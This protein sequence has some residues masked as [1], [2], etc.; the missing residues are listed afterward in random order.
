MTPYKDHILRATAAD[1]QIRAFAASTKDL[2]EYARTIH[3]ASPVAAI[4]LGRLLTAVAMMGTMMKND[5]DK[6][7]I[8]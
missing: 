3:N 4:A 7:T 1:G 6:L 5:S 2:A 8:Q